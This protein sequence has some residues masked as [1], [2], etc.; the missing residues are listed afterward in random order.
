MN[1]N[2]KY[3]VYKNGVLLES[4]TWYPV[5]GVWLA[6]ETGRLFP[7]SVYKIVVHNDSQYEIDGNLYNKNDFYI[8]NNQEATEILS[9]GKVIKCDKDGNKIESLDDEI[10]KS[11]M[12]KLPDV[13]KYNFKPFTRAVINV[14]RKEGMVV[15]I[16][17]K[18]HN[19]CNAIIRD[20]SSQK[21]AD[22]TKDMLISDAEL[23]LNTYNL[24][25][26]DILKD[27]YI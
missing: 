23:L 24:S 6:S 21:I 13:N 16:T 1:K 7:L 10:C 17:K 3:A 15:P 5:S 12:H 26:S 4:D 18:Q 20:L 27:K 2:I 22:G 19:K 14:I 9:N 25:I 8:C 11:M